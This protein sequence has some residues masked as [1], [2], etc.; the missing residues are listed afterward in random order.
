MNQLVPA[1]RPF[2]IS[3]EDLPSPWSNFRLRTPS[4]EFT[5][6]APLPGDATLSPSALPDSEWVTLGV[7]ADALPRLRALTGQKA[8]LF[9][10]KGRAICELRIEKIDPRFNVVVAKRGRP[11]RMVR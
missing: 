11:E 2:L 4:E 8:S 3:P 5:V 1:P 9:S 7:T 10:E 6:S